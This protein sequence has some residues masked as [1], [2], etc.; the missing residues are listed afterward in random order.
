M[1]GHFGEQLKNQEKQVQIACAAVFAHQLP[2]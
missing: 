2:T 1:A